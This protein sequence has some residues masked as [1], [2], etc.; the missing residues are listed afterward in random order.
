MANKNK[1]VIIAYFDGADKADMGVNQLKSW[2]KAN[3]DIKLGGIGILTYSEGKIQ[4]RNVGARA[5]GTGAKAGAII[6][7]VAGVL[8]GGV[9]LIGG[10]LAGLVGGGILG[11]LKHKS[12]GLSDA[13][14]Q[15]LEAELKAGKSAVVV[16]ADDHEVGPTKAQLEY[17]GGKVMSFAVP[18]ETV[19]AVEK[20][21][22][23]AASAPDAPGAPEQPQS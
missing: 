15:N 3:E 21:A 11:S 12:L 16:M 19:E 4:T 14:M 5:T 13:D 23:A 8:S 22:D 7:V 9:T 6:G 2:D 17:L 20:A 18:A 1:S 10:A